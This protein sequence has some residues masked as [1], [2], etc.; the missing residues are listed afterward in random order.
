MDECKSYAEC[1]K[2]IVRK[3]NSISGRLSPYQVFTDWVSCMALSISN[4]LT[5]FHGKVWKSREE[6]YLSIIKNYEKE[7]VAAFIE[8]SALLCGAM[9]YKISDILGEIYMES[10]CGNKNTG[11]FFT[12]FHVSIAC[13]NLVIPQEKLDTDEPIYINEPSCGAGGMI[14]AYALALQEKHVNYQQKMKVVAQDLDWKSVYMTYV[15][16]SLYGI[17]AVVVQGDTLLDPYH[18]DYPIERTFRTP[19]NMG[20][21]L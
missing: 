14:L 16:L 18:I 7:E 11:Q 19:R 10:G 21:L 1:K 4:S 5:L 8:M 13:A 9:G 20:V 2:Q 15:Q 12:P 17:D 6:H 3:I